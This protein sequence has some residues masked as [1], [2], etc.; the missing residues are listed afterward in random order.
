LKAF[1]QSAGLTALKVSDVACEWYYRTCTRRYEDWAL[2]A[3]PRRRRNTPVSR[4]STRRMRQHWHP[5]DVMT[6]AIAWGPR[7]GGCWPRPDW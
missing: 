7:S 4:P 6:A 1:A 3:S 2:Q 5:S